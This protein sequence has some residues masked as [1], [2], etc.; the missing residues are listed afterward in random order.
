VI[1]VIGP[2]CMSGPGG[3]SAPG[4]IADRIASAAAANGASVERV[5]RI[6]DDPAGD[7]WQLALSKAGIGH[8]AVLRDPTRPTPVCP[9]DR[10]EADDG[11][12]DADDPLAIETDAIDTDA[13]DT[14]ANHPDAP[15]DDDFEPSTDVTET[16]D[17]PVLDPADVGLALRYLADYRI[18]VAVHPSADVAGAVMVAADWAGAQVVVVSG[19]G[20]PIPPTVPPGT[21]VVEAQAGDGSAPGL[22]IRLGA[23]A[24]A[25]DRGVTAPKAFAGLTAELDGVGGP[26]TDLA[27]T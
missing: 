15:I 8:V 5:A 3:A 1:V 26:E 2:A 7:A 6:G 13:I 4:S 11:D 20:E 24:A 22:A 25:I 9:G 10:A 12:S 17:G 21:L 23:Y 16:F 27:I 19:P 18:L 14:G